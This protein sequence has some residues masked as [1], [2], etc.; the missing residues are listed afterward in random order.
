MRAGEAFRVAVGALVA[1][2]L[3][4]SLTMLGV[5]IGVAAGKARRS[6]PHLIDRDRAVI[7]GVERNEAFDVGSS[8]DKA[9]GG[10]FAAHP[11]GSRTES[12]IVTESGAE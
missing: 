5:V 12:G 3:R 4:S 10:G 1:N 6:V 2:K 11:Q 9:R 7:I 8:E